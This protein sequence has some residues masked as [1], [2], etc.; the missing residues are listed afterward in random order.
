MDTYRSP[1]LTAEHDLYRDNVRRFVETEFVPLRQQWIENGHSEP[2][3]WRRAGDAGLLLPDVPSEYGGGGADFGFDAIVYE[4]LG[5][6]L[7][8]GF[9]CAIQSIVAHYFLA[10]ATEEQKQKYL[11][12]MAS[13]EIICSIAMTEPG[14]GSD[15]QSV[16]TKAVRD[17][18][19]YV[20]NG[21]K[22]FITNGYNA[23]LIVL[24][25]K[26]NPAERAKGVSLL[27][28]ETDGLEGFR[29]GKPLKKIGMKGQDTSELFFDDCRVPVD[30]ILGGVEGQGFYQLMNQLGRE[31]LMIGLQSVS[32]LEAA[33]HH[34]LE[35]VRQREAFGQKL[36]D[37]QNTRFTLVECATEARIARTFVDDCIQRL[38]EGKLDSATASMAKYWCSERA[39]ENIHRLLQMH[40]G[41]GYIM[42]YPIAHLFADHRVAMIY[43]G[44]NEIM[45]ELIARSL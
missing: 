11:P 45:K 31:R 1:W 38:I 3:A 19:H 10:Y 20:V 24:V 16:R 44:S 13:G 39:Q 5:R 28:V 18:D 22:T 40:G 15:L 41:Y 8:S 29:R 42:D 43:G 2:E 32:A 6:A 21:S 30:N 12:K 14:T 4:E 37:F 26:T 9:G 23:N 7:V 33:V 27:L 36:F 35:Y 17:G 34:T 25:C